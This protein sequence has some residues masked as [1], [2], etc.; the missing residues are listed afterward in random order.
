[1]AQFVFNNYCYNFI[2]IFIDLTLNDLNALGILSTKTLYYNLINYYLQVHNQLLIQ[3]PSI[4]TYMLK[5]L[6]YGLKYIHLTHNF[7]LLQKA[8]KFFP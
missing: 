5:H 7:Y 8:I 1:M 4:L 6:N 2:I 3:S